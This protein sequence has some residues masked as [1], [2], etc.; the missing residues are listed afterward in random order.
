MWRRHFRRR[1][2]KFFKHENDFLVDAFVLSMQDKFFTLNKQSK[3]IFGCIF[4]QGV[5]AEV[6]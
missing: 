4:W 3:I 5:L 6:M 1:H 2:S